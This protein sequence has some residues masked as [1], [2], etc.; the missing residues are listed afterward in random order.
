[1]KNLK[2]PVVSHTHL[3]KH[4]GNLL[5]HWSPGPAQKMPWDAI[6]GVWRVS[7]ISIIKMH[8]SFFVTQDMLP[9][10]HQAHH[11]NWEDF[12]Q[13]NFDGGC[14]H[15]F[16]SFAMSMCPGFWCVCACVFVFFVGSNREPPR[17]I[18]AAT[19]APRETRWGHPMHKWLFKKFP[20]RDSVCSYCFPWRFSRKLCTI[21]SQSL[22][23]H[24][25]G[26]GL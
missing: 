1:M 26:I 5:A 18:L 15:A 23:N 6:R 3:Q 14:V 16:A 4:K 24:F 7:G 22:P 12:S 13:T 25:P 20:N 17:T 8:H 10:C 19:G 9:C 2:E 21:D 11:W